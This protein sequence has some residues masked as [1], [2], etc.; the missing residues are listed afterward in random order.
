MKLLC[1]FLSGKQQKKDI[2]NKIAS[3]DAKSIAFTTPQTAADVLQK[4]GK[5][6]VQ[7]KPNGRR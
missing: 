1:L 5:V 7:K 4:S 6:F 3:I 2:P